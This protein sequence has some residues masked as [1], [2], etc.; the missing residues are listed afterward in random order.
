MNQ[1]K[2]SCGL[3]REKL[4]YHKCQ[5]I[6][7]ET[8][9]EQFD[10]DFQFDGVTYKGSR[11]WRGDVKQNLVKSFI[12]KLLE[13]ERERIIKEIENQIGHW[14]ITEERTLEYDGLFKYLINLIKNK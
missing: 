6:D 12:S 4:G 10:K 5:K 1:E 7:N 8:W 2:C 11:H 9:E 13:A 14:G 3:I